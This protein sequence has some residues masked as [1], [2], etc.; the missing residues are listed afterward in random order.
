M[1]KQL[2][3]F[4]ISARAATYS[5]TITLTS[6]ARVAGTEFAAGE[7]EGHSDKDKVTFA[8]GKRS[9]VS[10]PAKLEIVPLRYDE[11]QVRVDWRSQAAGDSGWGADVK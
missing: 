11:T 6:D 3:S 7:Y 1:K 8:Q 2:L 10:E 4:S 5:F 9:L